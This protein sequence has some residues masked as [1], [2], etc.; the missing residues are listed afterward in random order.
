[1]FFLFL[2]LNEKEI[3][4]RARGVIYKLQNSLVNQNQVCKNGKWPSSKNSFTSGCNNSKWRAAPIEGLNENGMVLL[5][6]HN[7]IVAITLLMREI[8]DIAR[9]PHTPEEL[10]QWVTQTWGCSYESIYQPVGS[11]LKRMGKLGV[12]VFEENQTGTSPSVPEELDESRS[13]AGFALLKRMPK[14]CLYKCELTKRDSFHYTLKVLLRRNPK[15]S[16]QRSF[17]KDM[18]ASRSSL[19]IDSN[20]K[21]Q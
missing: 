16:L 13:F 18:G 1:M 11:F 19:R 5:K 15:D 6:L 4:T 8:L 2:L 3:S 12:L 9:T 10:M 20:V 14:S 21:Y 7:D 17:F